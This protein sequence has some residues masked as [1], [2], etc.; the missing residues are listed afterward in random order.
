MGIQNEDDYNTR[1]G[2]LIRVEAILQDKNKLEKL[3][4]IR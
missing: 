2:T 4:S 3:K 1:M